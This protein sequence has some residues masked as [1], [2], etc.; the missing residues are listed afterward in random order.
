MQTPNAEN[1]ENAADWL[2]LTLYNKA[3]QR[4]Q[5]SILGNGQNT[6]MGGV[7]FWKSELTEFCAKLSEFY[8][9]LA[10]FALSHE[11]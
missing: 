6:V 7:L 3:L 10:E 4:P 5:R 1:A 9:K 11:Q 8:E 2:S